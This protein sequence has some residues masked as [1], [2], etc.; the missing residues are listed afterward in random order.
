M[1]LE[2]ET[3]ADSDATVEHVYG[4][5]EVLGAR[6]PQLLSSVSHCWAS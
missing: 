4:T 3:L 1:T 6:G 2:V 5:A